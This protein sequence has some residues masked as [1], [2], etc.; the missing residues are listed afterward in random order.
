MK[1]SG[2]NPY[3][4]RR[5]CAPPLYEN[6]SLRFVGEREKK[7]DRPR[8]KPARRKKMWS[9]LLMNNK[10]TVEEMPQS[11]PIPPLHHA[12]PID[13]LGLTY[14][15]GHAEGLKAVK[16]RCLGHGRCRWA[17]AA[18][19]G[20][21]VDLV[22]DRVERRGHVA[23]LGCGGSV[24]ERAHGIL[25]RV[26]FLLARQIEA[27]LNTVAAIVGALVPGGSTCQCLF[28]YF[29]FSFWLEVVLCVGSVVGRVGGLRTWVVLGC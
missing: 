9:T 6:T 7:E 10:D 27:A 8:L 2:S 4:C 29:W 19:R 25:A 20:A 28:W 14:C 12:P 3:G 23:R 24:V 22:H 5:Q 17:D 15:H 1:P 13:R 11:R 16:G 21:V 26:L 18:R